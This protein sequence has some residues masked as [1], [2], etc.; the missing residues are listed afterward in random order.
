MAENR[1]AELLAFLVL[2]A[3][4]EARIIRK[5]VE[6]FALK[7]H[8]GFQVQVEKDHVAQELVVTVRLV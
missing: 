4:G 2:K 1:E 6:A 7:I 3:G 5:D 8:R